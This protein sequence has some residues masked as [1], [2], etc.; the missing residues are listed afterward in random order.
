MKSVGSW[1]LSKE[2]DVL[3]YEHSGGVYAVEV[4][5]A[6]WMVFKYGQRRAGPFPTSEAAQEHAEQLLKSE[7]L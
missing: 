2:P 5:K 6:G 7:K 3:R 1:K 4:T